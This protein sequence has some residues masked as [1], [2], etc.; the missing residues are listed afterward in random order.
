MPQ[1]P[2][3]GRQGRMSPVIARRCGSGGNGILRPA[4]SIAAGMPSTSATLCGLDQTS[5]TLVVHA[6]APRDGR[7]IRLINGAEPKQL[8]KEYLH[9]DVIPGT[10]PPKRLG[11]SDNI[12][13]GRPRP[14]Q[15]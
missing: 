9:K 4:A 13:P 14:V 10:S 3:T 15:P 7:R 11:A 12:Q 6:N 8:I 5:I 2:R 1:D